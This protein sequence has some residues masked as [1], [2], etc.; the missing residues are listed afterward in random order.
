MW[1]DGQ[2]MTALAINF[3]FFNTNW[4]IRYNARQHTEERQTESNEIPYVK[5]ILPFLDYYS[6]MTLFYLSNIGTRSGIFL[7]RRRI[8]TIYDYL[9]LF[10]AIYDYL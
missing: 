9:R 7:K 3:E 10:T 5:L 4:S 8:T 2:N 6:I 1:R